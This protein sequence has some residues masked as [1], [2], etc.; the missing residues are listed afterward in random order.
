MARIRSIKPELWV[1]ED[2]RALDLAG[3]LTF[4]ALI[5]QADDHGRLK[6]TAKHLA[7]VYVKGARTAA[8]QRQLDLMQAHNMILQYET[9]NGSYIALCN[10]GS[11][12]KVD[13]PSA[14]R[15]PE[16][17][18]FAE[19][20]RAVASSSESSPKSRE[21]SRAFEP[22]RAPADRIGS[23]PERIRETPKPPRDGPSILP[24]AK[25][26]LDA[27]EGVSGRPPS[28][29]DVETAHIWLKD[30]SRAAPDLV[31]TWMSEAVAHREAEKLDPAR[32]LSTLHGG[33]K[34]RY[35]SWCDDLD[36]AGQRAPRGNGAVAKPGDPD[37]IPPTA[38]A[39]RQPTRTREATSAASLLAGTES[40]ED[41]KA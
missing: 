36:A 5:S 27:W 20:S 18:K 7:D 21:D 12:Q 30:F 2:F 10:W 34:V 24:E 33:V 38:D 6:M 26:I 19:S 17:P 31:V 35:V 8:I 11:H 39:A 14:S 32:H 25:P 41:L 13:K 15:I 29:A 23:G 22:S 3:R 1:S 16:P 28:P 9:E 37:E 4:I 40:G